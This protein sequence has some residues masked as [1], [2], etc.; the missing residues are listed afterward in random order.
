LDS[1]FC[2]A[3]QLLGSSGFVGLARRLVLG[4]ERFKKF[5]PGL[6]DSGLRFAQRAIADRPFR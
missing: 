4:K 5:L 2:S 1:F 3:P 6:E